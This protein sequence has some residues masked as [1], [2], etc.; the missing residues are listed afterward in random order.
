VAAD[1]A[2]T[3]AKASTAD[4]RLLHPVPQSRQNVIRGLDFA[5]W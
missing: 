3:K 1:D 5:R 4:A 2:G